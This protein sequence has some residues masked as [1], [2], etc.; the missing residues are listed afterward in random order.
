MNYLEIKKNFNEDISSWDT[1][2]VENMKGMF[3]CAKSFNQ[4]LDSWDTS[5]VRNMKLMLCGAKSFNQPLDSWNKKS[6][7]DSWDTSYEKEC[8]L[9]L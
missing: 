5:N 9:L 7:V 2:N 1:S 8:F 3:W 6:N 4:P